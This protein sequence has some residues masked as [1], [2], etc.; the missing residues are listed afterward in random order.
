L[1]NFNISRVKIKRK[2]TINQLSSRRSSTFTNN[3]YEINKL[4]KQRTPNASDA[5]IANYT[6]NRRKAGTYLAPEACIEGHPVQGKSNIWSLGCVISVVFSY[7]YGGQEAVE[8]FASRRYEKSLD[9]RFFSFS[10]G[11]VPHKLGDAQVNNAVR[12]WFKHLRIKT[13]QQNSEEGAVFE[14]VIRFLGNKV[15]VID[16]KQR[17]STTARKVR[18]KLIKAFNAFRSMTNSGPSPHKIPKS[19]SNI[20]KLFRSIRGRQSEAG[21]HAEDWKI[22]LPAFVR[23]CAFGPNA[24]P[25]I[26]TTNGIL[27]AYSLEHVLLSSES[28]D[29]NNFDEDLMTYGQATPQDN[30]RQ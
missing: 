30:G 4:F 1:S 23:T 6:I 21:I 11:N 15:L 14:A 9:D 10:G 27:I 13:K 20:S 5:S 8:T 12:R 29:S 24:Q 28:G 16:P 7:I 18:E 26:Y 2:Q 17:Q 3:V 22:R 19:Q 25:L